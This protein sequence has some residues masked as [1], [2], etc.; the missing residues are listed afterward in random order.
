MYAFGIHVYKHIYK[1]NYICIMCFNQIAAGMRSIS[2]PHLLG[3][4]PDFR[5][6]YIFLI[7]LLRQDNSVKIKCSLL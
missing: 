6:S 1:H 2:H 5:H 7:W 4:V 3:K